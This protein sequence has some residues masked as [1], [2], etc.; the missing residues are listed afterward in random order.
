[1]DGQEVLTEILNFLLQRG[2][3]T[4]IEE[5][6]VIVEA[7]A[8][9]TEIKLLVILALDGILYPFITNLIKEN[10]NNGKTIG[11]VIIFQGPGCCQAIINNQQLPLKTRIQI[12]QIATNRFQISICEKKE[13]MES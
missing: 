1:M 3:N 4:N 2:K 11:Y 7:A 13:I 5:D 10:G 6:K 9:L 8:R 12:K